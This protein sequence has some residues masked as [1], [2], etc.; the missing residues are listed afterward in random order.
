MRPELAEAHYNLGVALWYSGARDRAIRE[1]RESVRL[2]PAAGAS[3]AFLGTALRDARRPGRRRAA[4]LQR[5]IALLPPTAAVYVDL[6]VTFLQGGELA[7]A[8]GQFEAGSERRSAIATRTR[9][10]L[11]DY[12]DCERP[13]L[14]GRTRRA[15]TPSR[16]PAIALL[17]EAQNVLGLMLGRN[18]ADHTE[19]ADAFR[20]AIELHPDFAEA[21]N[22][23]GLVLI[24][25]GD[26]QAGIAALREAVRISPDYADARTNLGAALTP[27]DAEDGVR[28]LEKAVRL[29]PT[30]VKAQF[31]LGVAYGAA[32]GH[33]VAKEI[34][35]LR[36]VIE[37]AP[38]FRARA[39]GAR[40]GTAP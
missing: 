2:D 19:V 6:G 36:K 5:A 24:Q 22:N 37:L 1:L 14:R 9:L 38:T 32:P 25:A 7:K 10:G 28:E 12:R 21:H 34:E 13:S 35:Q 33:G 3:H 40:Q 30:S 15:A 8:L 23:L 11:G 17:A 18:G 20:E 31:N 16:A 39:R 4:S 26:D 27:T 29:A